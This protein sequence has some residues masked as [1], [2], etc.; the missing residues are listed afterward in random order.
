M[1]GASRCGRPPAFDHEDVSA[2]AQVVAVGVDECG[3]VAGCAAVGAGGL[4][5][6]GVPLDSVEGDVEAAGAFEEADALV[7]QMVDPLPALAGGLLAYAP[8]PS[9]V[10][11]G[12]PAGSVGA[13]FGQDLAAQVGPAVPPVADLYRFG[14]G[15]ADRRGQSR[16]GHTRRRTRTETTIRRPSTGTSASTR[17]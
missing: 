7:E 10:H 12:S 14:E 2:S 3:L 11:S 6:A 5:H 9:G 4:L 13:D 1:T 17:P 16:T 15:L 8:R